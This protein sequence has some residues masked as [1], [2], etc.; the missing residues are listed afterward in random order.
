[1]N[2]Q[3]LAGQCAKLKCCLNF[4]AAAYAESQNKMPHKDVVLQAKDADYYLFKTDILKREITYSTD[5]SV[6]SNLVTIS[7]RRAHEIIALNKQGI[8]VDALLEK[9]DDAANS[10]PEFVDLADQDSLTRFDKSRRRKRGGKGKGGGQ[11]QQSR[12]GNGDK[13]DKSDR[14]SGKGD[15]PRRGDQ[16]K[17]KNGEGGKNDRQRPPRKKQPRGQQ[18]QDSQQKTRENKESKGGNKENHEGK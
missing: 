6:P 14:Q 18:R 2:P 15:N 4:E 3:K 9:S 13:N 16:P 17:N 8:K 10:V 5:K 1:M 7:A 12:K 11:Q